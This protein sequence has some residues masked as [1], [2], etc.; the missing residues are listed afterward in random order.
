MQIR[1]VRPASI[2]IQLAKPA[3][4]E[5]STV[6]YPVYRPGSLMKLIAVAF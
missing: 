2:A 3:V 4:L 1:L 5:I 6:A